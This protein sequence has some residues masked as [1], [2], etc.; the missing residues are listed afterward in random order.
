MSWGLSI[1]HKTCM[2]AHKYPPKLG[3]GWCN[4][5][6]Q[7]SILK[8]RNFFIGLKGQ[9]LDFWLFRT[10]STWGP[11]VQPLGG[12]CPDPPGPPPWDLCLWV[13]VEKKLGRSW[14]PKRTRYL[15][16]LH[17]IQ[18]TSNMQHV[19]NQYPPFRFHCKSTQR[20]PKIVWT[21]CSARPNVP[22]PYF[23]V[24]AISTCC[25]FLSLRMRLKFITYHFVY[26]C[27]QYEK[28]FGR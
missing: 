17:N 2:G 18:H 11:L 4:S 3:Y 8:I 23:L 24:L 9:S 12:E 22:K 28:A 7:Y 15:I 10:S 13:C 19:T 1:F 6:I 20:N 27:N 14:T 5:K 26:A 25:F 21:K 16:V